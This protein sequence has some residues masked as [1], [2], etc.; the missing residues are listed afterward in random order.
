MPEGYAL[1]PSVAVFDKKNHANN[2]Y[3]MCLSDDGK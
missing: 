1:R 2:I 3:Q